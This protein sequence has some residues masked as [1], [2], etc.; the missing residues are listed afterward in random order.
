M[1]KQVVM[2]EV[3]VVQDYHGKTTRE[4]NMLCFC[5][6]PTSTFAMQEVENLTAKGFAYMYMYNMCL[7]KNK[8][9]YVKQLNK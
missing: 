8:Q 1:H 4:L 2:Q 6:L 3:L 9:M 5:A 7:A